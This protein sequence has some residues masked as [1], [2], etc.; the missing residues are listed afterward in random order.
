MKLYLSYHAK[1][2]SLLAAVNAF[3]E[4][5]FDVSFSDNPKDG[6]NADI[7][8]FVL[9]QQL[10]SCNLTDLNERRIDLIQEAKAIGKTVLIV[11]RNQEDKWGLY[12]SELTHSRIKG[13]AGTSDKNAQLPKQIKV[14]KPES[15]WNSYEGKIE[16]KAEDLM[17]KDCR[18]SVKTGYVNANSMPWYYQRLCGDAIVV[19]TGGGL[20]AK[21]FRVR[22]LLLL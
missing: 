16:Y 19:N 20:S 5:G 2:H 4:M 6:N 18:V 9:P 3:K 1:P 15:G 14:E 10:F 21:L 8:G 11:Y 17:L 22:R 13:I 12:D 7:I